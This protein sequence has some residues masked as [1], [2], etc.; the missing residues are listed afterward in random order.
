MGG[1]R[2]HLPRTYWTFLAASLAIAAIPPFSGFFSKDQIL[3]EVYASPYGGVVFWGVGIVTAGITSFYIFRLFFLTFHGESRREASS[4]YPE[5]SANHGRQGAPV[6]E[7]PPVMTWPLILLGVLSLAGGWIGIPALFGGGD[8]WNRFLAPVFQRAAPLLEEHTVPHGATTELLF[9]SIPLVVSLSGILLAY[10]LYVRRPD[11]AESLAMR[12]RGFH[13][14]VWN[15]YY[16]DEIYRF[17]LV[18]PLLVGSSEVLW[19][20]VDVWVIDGTVNRAAR[21]TRRMSSN[22][23]GVR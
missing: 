3:W 23:S 7:S 12:L 20:A 1:L 5:S 8:H 2:R 19:K 21:W 18:R 13:T 22:S 14:L 4:A 17:L 10:L 15:K 11:L 9:T 6:H 16:V